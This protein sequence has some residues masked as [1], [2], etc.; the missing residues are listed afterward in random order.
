MFDPRMVAGWEVSYSRR[1]AYAVPGRIYRPL[2]PRKWLLEPDSVRG[3]PSG[4][5]FR[6]SVPAPRAPTFVAD[7]RSVF[8]DLSVANNQYRIRESNSCSPVESRVS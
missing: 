1:T 2:F 6:I 4:A 7:S 8:G 3:Q 5:Q